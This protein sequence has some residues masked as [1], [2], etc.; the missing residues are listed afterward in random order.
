MTANTTILITG[1]SGAIGGALARRYA[2]PGVRLILNG[3]STEALDTLTAQCRAQGAEAFSAPVDL[4]NAAAREDWLSAI[5]ASHVP[6]I[7]IA[8]AGKN[9]HPVAPGELESEADALA[10][11]DIN[12]AT[13]MAMARHLIPQMRARGHGQLVFISSLAAWYGLPTTPAYSASKAGIKAYAEGLRGWLAPF[14]IGVSVVLPGYVT[15]PMC[16]AMPGPKPGEW[17]PERAASAI[18]R[19]IK[20]NRARIMFPFWLCWGTQW[21]A[22]LPAGL[23]QWLLKRLGYARLENHADGADRHD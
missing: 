20:A 3:R 8:C 17:T 4:N 9:A 23:S 18:Q 2:A 1:A 21:L 12:L 16:H 10:V 13:P 6:D 19:G 11:M 14:G 5:C 22:M 15:S 7:F